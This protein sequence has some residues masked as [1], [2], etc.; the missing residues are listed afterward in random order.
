VHVVV[1]EHVLHYVGQAVLQLL[2]SN[3]NPLLHVVHVV[4][5]EHVLQFVGQLEE[6]VPVNNKY[7]T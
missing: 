3:K 4:A 6:H 5:L 7:P 1:S 2:F